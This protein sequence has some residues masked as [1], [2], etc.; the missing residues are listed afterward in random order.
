MSRIVAGWTLIVLV[1]VIG[2]LL[3]TTLGLMYHASW[4][5]T[6]FAGMWGVTVGHDIGKGI[7]GRRWRGNV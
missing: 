5:G 2:S 4:L 7:A 3:C 1:M 6:I